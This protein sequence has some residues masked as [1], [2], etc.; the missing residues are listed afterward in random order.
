MCG[1]NIFSVLF[2]VT[3]AVSSSNA[4]AD[5]NAAVSDFIWV[6]E[7]SP[8]RRDFFV[9][10]WSFYKGCKGVLGTP[11]EAFLKLVAVRGN[12][13]RILPTRESLKGY[14]R[15]SDW[16]DG[17]SVLAYVRLFTALDTHYLFENNNFIEVRKA[18]G[19]PS[20]GELVPATY[21]KLK[22]HEPTVY[23]TGPGYGVIR[24]LVDAEHMIYR[25]NE[26]VKKDGDYRIATEVIAK[27]VEI[28]YPIYE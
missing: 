4:R 1:W 28:L 20:W 15:F 25:A 11:D 13:K 22:L 18:S 5:N 7:K 10:G 24:Y 2:A 27:N 19:S 16:G 8:V 12:L 3:L 14:V 21:E 17:E 6:D 23:Q 9:S 26:I